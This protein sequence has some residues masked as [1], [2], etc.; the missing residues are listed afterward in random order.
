MSGTAGSYGL[1]RIHE[2]LDQ[3]HT[4]LREMGGGDDDAGW[5]AVDT[6][7]AQAWKDLGRDSNESR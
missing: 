4:R 6:A 5:S 1:D 3:I 2:A 7:L